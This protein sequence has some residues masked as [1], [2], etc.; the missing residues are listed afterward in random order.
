VLLAESSWEGF[1]E[2]PGWVTEGYATVFEEVD[3]E[4]EA[5][6]RPSPDVVVVPLGIGAFASAAAA[7]YRTDHFSSELWLLGAEPTAAAC[8]S[9]SIVAGDRLTLPST[10]V[11]VME[12]LARGL[13]SVL[14]WPVVSQ[15]FDAVVAVDDARALEAEALLA[16]HGVLASPTGSA[17]FAGVIQALVDRAAGDGSIPLGPASRVLVVITE[18]SLA[19]G[20]AP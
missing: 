19:A 3:D 16:A 14:A 7:W 17:A 2:V 11:T 9:A 20:G 8:W 1:D 5:R 4:L 18:G 6:G 12:G 10:G 13:P 15:S